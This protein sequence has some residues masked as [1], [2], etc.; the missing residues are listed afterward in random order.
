[1]LK[2]FRYDHLSQMLTRILVDKPANIENEL[3]DL[4]RVMKAER[5]FSSTELLKT[6]RERTA[7]DILASAQMELLKVT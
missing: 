7:T 4:S 2:H 1:M 5:L 3:E 6:P